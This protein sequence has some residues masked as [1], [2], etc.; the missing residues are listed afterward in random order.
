[1]GRKK[2]NPGYDAAKIRNEM[3][4]LVAELYSSNDM[5]GKQK[6]NLSLRAV[7]EE[8]DISVSKVVKL[9]ITGGYYTS[10]LYEQVIDLYEAGNSV[11]TI[12]KRLGISRVT[13]H[14][15]LPYRKCIYNAKETSLNA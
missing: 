3:M 10:D 9:L 8:L 6:N 15:Y 4:E 14:S 11:E 13:V 2:K 7:A 5:N 1:M 12:Q